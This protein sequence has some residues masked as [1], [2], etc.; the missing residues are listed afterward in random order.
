M[1]I[2]VGEIEGIPIQI[3]IRVP[4]TENEFLDTVQAY[5]SELVNIYT[6]AADPIFEQVSKVK[7][8]KTSFYGI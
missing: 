8:M 1:D 4:K 5:K 3:L 7:T 6:C 2:K